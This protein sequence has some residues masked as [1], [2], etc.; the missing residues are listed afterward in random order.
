[1]SNVGTTFAKVAVLV[2]GAIIGAQLSHWLDRYMMS[3]AEGKPDHDK[4]RYAQGLAP[5]IQQ[6]ST[7]TQTEH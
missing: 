1:M 7:E 2:G 6:S 5:V 3:Q 4:L